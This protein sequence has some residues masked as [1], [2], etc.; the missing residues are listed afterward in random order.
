MYYQKFLEHLPPLYDN[1]SQNIQSENLQAIAAQFPGSITPQMMEF[2]N[3][4][5]DFL[6]PGEIYLQLG[7]D[8]ISLIAA[9]LNHP[10]TSAYLVSDLDN[11]AAGEALSLF[12]LEEQVFYCQQGFEEFFSEFKLLQ[13][14]TKIGVFFYQGN[15]DYRSALLSLLFVKNFLAEEA[16]IFINYNNCSQVHQAGYDFIT[17]HPQCQPLDNFFEGNGV[18][19]LTWHSQQQYIK[20][21]L[22]HEIVVDYSLYVPQQFEADTKKAI[23]LNVEQAAQTLA[24]QGKFAQAAENYLLVLNGNRNNA[25]AWHGLALVY[26]QIGH[27]DQALNCVAKAVSIEAFEGTYYYSLGFIFQ[28]MGLTPKAIEAYEMAIKLNPQYLDAYNNLG[29]I[30]LGLGDL[31]QAAS[32]YRRAISTNTKHKGSYFNLLLTLNR[33]GKI[34]EAIEVANQAAEIFPEDFLWQL[35]KHLM[36]PVIYQ[37]KTE[38]A[39]HRQNFQEG[40]NRLEQILNLS[41]PESR[42]SALAALTR[43]NNFYLAYQGLNHLELQQSYAKL[44]E[45]ILDANYPH[46]RKSL[47]LKHHPKNKIK[48]G[49]ISGYLHNHVVSKLTLGWVVNHQRDKF[50]IYCYYLGSQNDEV[51]EIY[52]HNCHAFYQSKNNLELLSQ[53]IINDKLD[54]LVFLDIGMLPEI[55]ILAGLRLAPIQCTTW[56]HPETT[57]LSTVDYFLSSELMEPENAEF[58]YSEQLIKLPNIGISYPHPKIPETIPPRS[59]F[60][61][62][63][64]RLIYLCPQSLFKYV[65]QYDY[66]FAQIALK[67][68]KAQFVF[69]ARPNFDISNLFR[70]R[71]AK[72]FSEVGLNFDYYCVFLSALN[73]EDYLNLNLVADVFLDSFQWSGGDTTLEALACN[74]PVVTCPGEFMRGR[75]SFGILKMLGVTETIASTEEEYVAISVRLGLDAVWRQQIKQKCQKNLPN[76]Y[77][78][79]SC[80]RALE[81]FYEEAVSQESD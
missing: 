39:V 21:P 32:L 65:P 52:Q 6:A 57:G 73:H 43:H 44:V 56:A 22:A 72:T 2:L 38:I 54:I 53:Q 20:P 50:K 51:T 4:S 19:I 74:L 60:G 7:D 11:E 10:T 79:L 18:Q 36:L 69:L 28:G 49:Y 30:F 46:L 24:K 13:P 34:K 12:D 9:L 63:E 80:V 42:K 62:K 35:K 77:N 66:I 71:L 78:D 5:V 76:I 17:A 81:K 68:P 1:W 48:V 31:E 37:N 29:N 26:Y 40:L 16:L 23:V 59:D 55:T 33:Q 3:F 15:P 45:K 64:G 61:L 27:Y 14:Q 47:Q 75:H 58:H 67:V 8:I 70:Q 41:T 25:K